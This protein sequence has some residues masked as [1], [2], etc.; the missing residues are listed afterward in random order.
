[1][2]LSG[3]LVTPFPEGPRPKLGVVVVE[4]VEVEVDEFVDVVPALLQKIEISNM[5]KYQP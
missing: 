3:L 1:M 2:P 5:G 4:P